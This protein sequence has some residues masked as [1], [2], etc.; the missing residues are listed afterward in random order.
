M[1][2]PINRILEGL[3]GDRFIKR[4]IRHDYDLIELVKEGLPM[5]SVAFLQSNLGFTNKEM[6]H[7]LAIS[8][9]TYQRRI[10]A[11]SR[12]TQDETEKAISLSEI[13]E[14]GIDVFRSKPDFEGWLQTKVPAMG[15]Q[16][17]VDML[18]SMI[19]RQHVMDGLNRIL[20]GIFS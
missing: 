12:L 4:P 19:G 16:R 2:V 20:H 1:Q 11:K 13:Y 15:N 18:D 3:G 7:I 17:P 8:E 6:S 14:K 5:E 9:S 10:R